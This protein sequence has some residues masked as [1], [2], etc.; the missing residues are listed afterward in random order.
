V[1]YDVPS[2]VL[3]LTG[4]VKRAQGDGKDEAG[5]GGSGSD[6]E[7]LSDEAMFRM[8]SKLAAYFAAAQQSKR[9]AKAQ[10]DELLNFKLRVLALLEA[11]MKKVR[12]RGWAEQR[13]FWTASRRLG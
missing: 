13:G 9:G 6:E 8:D 12:P 5:E 11:F 7:G 10:R 1:L 4:G 2:C 3:L